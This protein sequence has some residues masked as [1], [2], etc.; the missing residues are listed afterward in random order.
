MYLILGMNI[1]PIGLH[2]TDAIRLLIQGAVLFL[3]TP[4]SETP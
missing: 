2:A 3:E 1:F 4:C